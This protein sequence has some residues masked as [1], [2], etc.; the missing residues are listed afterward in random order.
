LGDLNK[1]TDVR[2]I[3]RHQSDTITSYDDY[4]LIYLSTLGGTRKGEAVDERCV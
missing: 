2:Q 4:I 3:N 1:A